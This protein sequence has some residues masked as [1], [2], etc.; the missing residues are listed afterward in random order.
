ML[1]N[2]LA[3]VIMTGHE[4]KQ[5]KVNWHYYPLGHRNISLKKQ[6]Q[7]TEGYYGLFG[8]LA[9]FERLFF[10]SSASLRHIRKSQLFT[11]PNPSRARPFLTSTP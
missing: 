6:K 9:Y 1:E 7:N 5:V 10:P 2:F 8:I 3:A 4:K 11:V